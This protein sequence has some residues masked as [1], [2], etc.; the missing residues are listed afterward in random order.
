MYAD[1]KYNIKIIY[2]YTKRHV[3]I[4]YEA[5]K[6]YSHF[7]EPEVYTRTSLCYTID[8]QALPHV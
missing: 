7:W 8:L 2:F 1:T 4:N 6:D 5:H 3:H